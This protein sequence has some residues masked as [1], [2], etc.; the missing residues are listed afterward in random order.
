M[1]SSMVPIFGG[2]LVPIESGGVETGRIKS[3]RMLNGP[4]FQG[5]WV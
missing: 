2:K 5:N 3:Q 4:I 1:G